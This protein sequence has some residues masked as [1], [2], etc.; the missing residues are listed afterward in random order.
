MWAR[1]IR[2][3]PRNRAGPLRGGL[4][5]E[6]TGGEKALLVFPDL[7]VCVDQLFELAGNDLFVGERGMPVAR[8]EAEPVDGKEEDVLVSP[9]PEFLHDF[10]RLHFDFTVDHIRG[11]HD[12]QGCGI[13]GSQALKEVRIGGLEVSMQIVSGLPG[14]VGVQ[15]RGEVV[16]A[17]RNDDDLR[18]PGR[19][20]VLLLLIEE[21]VE[22]Y[23]CGSVSP[24]EPS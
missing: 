16:G 15:A 1:R 5:Q 22:G 17:E 13:A 6:G 9:L 10:L 3:D 18:L 8:A 19:V 2:C 4:E 7:R 24:S 14:L 12:E 21:H 20:A 11:P 23:A